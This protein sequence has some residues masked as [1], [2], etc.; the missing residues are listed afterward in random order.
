MAFFK[1]FSFGARFFFV[2]EFSFAYIGATFRLEMG[3]QIGLRKRFIVFLPNSIILASEM[4]F[5]SKFFVLVV[6]FFF[7]LEF[8]LRQIIATF[9]LEIG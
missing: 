4:A 2:P 1:N 3:Q 5:F 8:S 7:V 6:I 9:R